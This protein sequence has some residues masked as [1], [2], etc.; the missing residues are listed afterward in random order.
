MKK[1]FYFKK[2]LIL[3]CTFLFIISAKKNTKTVLLPP[4]NLSVPF[5]GA[6]DNSITL[7]WNKPAEYSNIASYD[8]YQD[9]KLIANSTKLNF[10]ASD[11]SPN[12]TYSF[13]IKSKDINNN[14]SAESNKISVATLKPLKVIDITAYGAKGDGKTLNTKFIQKAID[15][16]KNDSIIFIPEGVF[17]SGAIFL[18]S[19]INLKIQGTLSG[20]DNVEDYP[21]TSKRFPYYETN[22]Y[23]GLINAYTTDYGSLKNIKIYGTGTVNGGAL[24]KD[25]ALT[26]LALKQMKL[27]SDPARADL[28]TIKGVNNLY[29]GGIKLI[30]PAEH[31]IFI[32]YC[33]NITIDGIDVKTY[34]IHNADG[35]DLAVSENI[36]VFNSFFDTGDDCI[37]FNAGFCY[38]G[39]QENIP[40]SNIRVFNC[41]TKRG[42]GG[43]VFGSYTS[44]W[45]KNVL[46]EDCIFN[47]TD[48]GI[49]FKTSKIIGGGAENILIR[50]IVMKKIKMESIIFDSK[51]TQT[52]AKPAETA[53]QFKNITIKNIVS[54][55][56]NMFGIYI[57][58]LKDLPNTNIN[59]ENITLKNTVG[60]KIKN[61]NDSTFTNVTIISDNKNPWDIT[62]SKN[63]KFV[64]CKPKPKYKK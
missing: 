40:C 33:K 26:E 52:K 14:Q 17:L 37:N 43:V 59:F 61:L 4:E 22:N 30:N 62:D 50:D 29:I 53:G 5:M 16:C 15:E 19:N 9:D 8:I 42:H 57:D 24:S 31:T 56:N 27:K 11:L 25:P 35:V 47:G 10:T 32:S 45:I 21:F 64:K 51:Y 36:N 6:S 49:R 3:T 1:N 23:M 28:I 41:E 7:I 38:Y 54:E 13:F 12:T 46:I 55:E 48:R 2:I 20:S 18:K 44:G 60:A 58:G 63:L 39:V 34:D